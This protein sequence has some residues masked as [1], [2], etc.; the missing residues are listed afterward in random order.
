MTKD[1]DAASQMS[2]DDCLVENAK[3]VAL[4]NEGHP[5]LGDTNWP[6]MVLDMIRIIDRLKQ[7]KEELRQAVLRTAKE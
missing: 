3:K 4:E 1:S 2:I 6:L 5:F 7:E